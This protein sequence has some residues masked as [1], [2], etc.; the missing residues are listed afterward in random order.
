[1]PM[2]KRPSEGECTTRGAKCAERP[3]ISPTPLSASRK[4]EPPRV[5]AKTRATTWFWGLLGRVR[6]IRSCNCAM[7]SWL[8]SWCASRA[9]TWRP[10]SSSDML[11]SASAGDAEEQ[12][13]VARESGDPGGRGGAG[14]GGTWRSPKSCRSCKGAAAQTAA[15]WSCDGGQGLSSGAATS[16]GRPPR[17]SGRPT[18]WAG[19]SKRRGVGSTLMWAETCRTSTAPIEPVAAA[20][21]EAPLIWTKGIA[22][23]CVA[24]RRPRSG[25]SLPV[26]PSPPPARNA[27]SLAISA[28]VASNSFFSATTWGLA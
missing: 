10:N 21:A 2:T 8:N 18:S 13:E 7:A 25:M 9:S 17:R 22:A 3:T 26:P 14:G 23:S 1:M 4:Q 27:R 5:F 28:S 11:Q 20:T 24:R 19:G 12:I 15:P 6:E 16:G